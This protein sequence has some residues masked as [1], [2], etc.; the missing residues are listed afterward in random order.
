MSETGAYLFFKSVDFFYLKCY[1]LTH[2]SVTIQR[3]KVSKN[4][5]GR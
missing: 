5:E 2:K 1:Y 4:K 3:E